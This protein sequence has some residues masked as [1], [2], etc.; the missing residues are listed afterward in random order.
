MKTFEKYDQ[1]TEVASQ[2]PEAG[3]RGVFIARSV[4]NSLGYKNSYNDEL[5]CY[6]AM[7]LAIV[8]TPKSQPVGT[9]I[10]CVPN[11]NTGSFMLYSQS[12]DISTCKIMISDVVGSNVDFSIEKSVVGGVSIALAGSVPGIYLVRV[13]DQVSGA[14]KAAETLI[15]I[16]E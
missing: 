5:L 7:R 10:K 1:L 15:I 9:K 16:N 13:F 12:I 4:L 2:C 3:G 6:P 8:N 11:P 14:L